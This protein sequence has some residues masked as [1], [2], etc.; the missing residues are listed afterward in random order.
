M[1]FSSKVSGLPLFEAM[2]PDEDTGEMIE[3]NLHLL[4]ESKVSSGEK[5]EGEKS[6]KERRRKKKRGKKERKMTQ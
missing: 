3:T 5:D 4:E 6:S 2:L 1:N